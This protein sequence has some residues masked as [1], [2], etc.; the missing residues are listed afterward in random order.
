MPRPATTEP[1]VVRVQSTADLVASIPYLVGFTPRRSVVVVSLRGRRL[2]CGVVA[3]VDLPPPDADRE[4]A[5]EGLV[6]S[7]V[8]PLVRDEPRQVAVVV[9][10]DLGWDDA[11]RPHQDVVDRLHDA[12]EA[13]G[14]PVK[15]AAYVGGERFWSYSC[16]EPACCPVGG[17]A[18]GDLPGGVVPASF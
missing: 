12:F 15:E 16:E 14:V 13:H 9:H 4:P 10:D 5:V 7:L 6:A 8:P 1:P 11:W 18:L 3:R 2:R 17:R